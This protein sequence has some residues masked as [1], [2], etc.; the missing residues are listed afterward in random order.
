MSGQLVGEV[1]AASDALRTRGLSERGFHAL[2]AIAEKA[3]THT[4]QGSVRWDHICAA[5]YGASKRTAERAVLDLK[6]SGAVRVVKP[7]FNNGHRAAAPIYEIQCLLDPATQVSDSGTAD[8]DTQVSVLGHPDTDKPGLDTDTQ[9]VVL[10]GSIDE[11]HARA[12]PPLTK[13]ERRK[14]ERAQLLQVIER[15]RD[16][17]QFGRLDDL[18]DCP[19]HSN[20]RQARAS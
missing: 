16:C 13:A 10:D 4:R 20:F 14:A 2:I 9:G 7:G 1:I 15:C 18:S 12:N 19:R 17:D 8:P 3:A 11:L 5:L 6:Q